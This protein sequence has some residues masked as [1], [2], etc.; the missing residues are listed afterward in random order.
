VLGSSARG[1]ARPRDHP[2]PHSDA[3]SHVVAAGRDAGAL[4]ARLR[5]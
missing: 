2:G 5:R 4:A 1:V 3:A